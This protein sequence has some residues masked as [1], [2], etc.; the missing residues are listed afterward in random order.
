MVHR[1]RDAGLRQVFVSQAHPVQRVVFEQSG[2]LGQLHQYL[3]LGGRGGR[4][5]ALDQQA[6]DPILQ[7]LDPLRDG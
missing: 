1:H 4:G 6:A 3:A 7:R 5:A 2:L